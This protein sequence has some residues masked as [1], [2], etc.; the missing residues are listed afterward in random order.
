MRLYIN[1]Y[2]YK[3]QF[4][5]FKFKPLKKKSPLLLQERRSHLIMLLIICKDNTII[6]FFLLFTFLSNGWA[7]RCTIFNVLRHRNTHLISGMHI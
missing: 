2:L 6:F 3:F 5:A 7:T 1:L 4:I